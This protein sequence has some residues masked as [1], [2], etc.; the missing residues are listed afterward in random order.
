MNKFDKPY[1]IITKF[2]QKKILEL[3][4][5][6]SK[7]E[8]HELI[9]Y[10]YINQLPLNIFN[11]SGNNLIHEIINI[12]NTTELS[13][14]NGIK[15]LVLNNVNPDKINKDNITP[16][17]LA[18]S[19]QFEDI[20]K[21]LVEIKVNINAQD[22]MKSTPVHYLLKGDIKMFEIKEIKSLV[23]Y[24]KSPNINKNKLI[25]KL[26][27]DI[28]NNL[29]TNLDVPLLDT[30]KKTIFNIISEDSSIK[31]YS[32]HL[33][34]EIAKKSL[35]ELSTLDSTNNLLL[36]YKEFIKSKITSL[37][38]INKI[39]I[40]IH[41]KE[42]TS[43]GPED[44][45]EPDLS[46][47]G[48]IKNG[49]NKKYI[50]KLFKD[51]I[52]DIKNLNSRFKVTQH[53]TQLETTGEYFIKIFAYYL[54]KHEKDTRYIVDIDNHLYYD[55]GP[56]PGNLIIPKFTK[57]NK[58]MIH[59]YAIDNESP[60]IDI[61]NMRYTAAGRPLII[62]RFNDAPIA[63]IAPI[64]IPLPINN[65]FD[66]IYNLIYYLTNDIDFVI[67]DV[68]IQGII[69]INDL[70]VS[71]ILIYIWYLAILKPDKLNGFINIL[72]THLN[73]IGVAGDPNIIL[74]TAAAVP[75]LPGRINPFIIMHPLRINSFAPNIV[76]LYVAG[77]SLI[78]PPPPLP[79]PPI[80]YINPEGLPIGN[81]YYNI[82]FHTFI[83]KWM[84]AYNDNKYTH[85]GLWLFNMYNEY[86]MIWG[87]Y[88]NPAL[89][90][91]QIPYLLLLLV[92]S[93]INNSSNILQGIYSIS[94]QFYHNIINDHV[95]L[96]NYIIYL[97]DINI[98]IPIIDVNTFYNNSNINIACEKI[99]NI[100]SEMTNKPLLQTILNIIFLLKNYHL[101]PPPVGGAVHPFY[102]R[103][104]Q[105]LHLY[106]YTNFKNFI[107]DPHNKYSPIYNMST[108]MKIYRNNFHTGYEYQHFLIAYI[109]GM[110]YQGCVPA[111]KNVRLHR[112]ANLIANQRFDNIVSE[113]NR[114]GKGNKKDTSKPQSL[115]NELTIPIISTNGS[116]LG[117]AVIPANLAKNIPGNIL[118]VG[119]GPNTN[120]PQ[121]LL[122]NALSQHAVE[123]LSNANTLGDKQKI[124]LYNRLHRIKLPLSHIS[125][126]T[127]LYY[128]IPTYYN[129]FYMLIKNIGTF[130]SKIN[131][132]IIK[133]ERII[134]QTVRGT[135]T[136]L[137][138]VFTE[139]YPELVF[140]CKQLEYNIN[141]IKQFNEL[142]KDDDDINKFN[143]DKDNTLG[144][145]VFKK[146][147][148]LENYDFSELAKI[149]NKINSYY[150]IY[151]YIYRQ[152]RMID[153]PAFNYYQIPINDNSNKYDYYNN[154]NNTLPNNIT[155][156][157]QLN[158]DTFPTNPVVGVPGP[159]NLKN[160]NNLNIGNYENLLLEY[161]QGKYPTNN[162]LLFNNNFISAKNETV[163][164]SLYNSLKL[165]FELVIKKIISDYCIPANQININEIDNILDALNIPLGENKSLIKY[166][167]LC[168]V[169]QTGIIDIINNYIESSI[170][171]YYETMI[172][173]NGLGNIDIYINNNIKNLLNIENLE[174][175]LTLEDYANISINKHELVN[176]LKLKE[177]LLLYSDDLTNLSRFK[178]TYEVKI[179]E[180]ILMILL[181]NNINLNLSDIENNTPID[182][183]IKQ[184]NYNILKKL[185]NQDIFVMNN[186]YNNY[187]YNNSLM[188]IKKIITTNDISKEKLCN[189]LN[190]FGAHLYK[191]INSLI[192]ANE[193]FG[194]NILKN[195]EESFWI[196]SY[197]TLK[198]LTKLLYNIDEDFTMKDLNYIV[199]SLYFNINDLNK[200]YLD[201]NIK[202]FNI[203]ENPNSI[204]KSHI[205]N[206]I[207]QEIENLEKQ[208]QNKE[209][210]LKTVTN[211]NIRN[212][213]NND[214][215]KITNDLNKYNLNK[216]DIENYINIHTN[217]IINHNLKDEQQLQFINGWN[218]LLNND[219]TMKPNNYNLLLLY[220]LEKQKN[221]ITDKK[222]NELK[223]ILPVFKHISHLVET[224]FTTKKYIVDN[225]IL[226][227][228][229]E[230]II[231]ITRLVIGTNLELIIRKVLYS[232][233]N[234][235]LL[236]NI[237]I[238]L[239]ID[240]V[241][242]NKLNGYNFSLKTKLYKD[243]CK[244]M[245][246]YAL[247]VFENNIDENEF[248]PLTMRDLLLSYFDLFNFTQL[249]I[250]DNIITILKTQ[251][252]DYFDTFGYRCI[253]LWLVNTEN[254]FKYFIKNYRLLEMQIILN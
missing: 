150:Y 68:D 14:L 239:S 80:A 254:I 16:L 64:V 74:P 9:Q 136:N 63:P 48:L 88:L 109:F 123:L 137:K 102:D 95:D 206:D 49:D 66:V 141:S 37:L 99:L 50:K 91:D 24:N 39:P 46:N 115:I 101:D 217:K 47:Y 180:K 209:E 6:A 60:I 55:K 181:A 71:N 32:N 202:S 82:S 228:I 185:K 23:P 44:P 35:T 240:I 200:D 40:E 38:G 42:L 178:N 241:F 231:E 152:N 247:E 226:K 210:L 227:D 173:N 238:E 190:N 191:D 140:N 162:Y 29:L 61:K 164:P 121:S 130:Q 26:K 250:P 163:P 86:A 146:F 2:D 221:I 134:D 10:A 51:T 8:I 135:T 216:D 223:N 43:W 13:K 143:D 45:G 158:F 58:D 118:I 179:N 53:Y 176:K 15:L 76:G 205:L 125:D 147:Q 170:Y 18:C 120:P 244:E 28:I 201:E 213:I 96:N 195:L 131:I 248:I 184:N 111:I 233:F 73:T 171:Y 193:S 246:K 214:I 218:Q 199:S 245:V 81:I 117:R 186:K 177:T 87:R 36:Y 166:E 105:F 70:L 20:V 89:Y 169:L 30:L 252:I 204:F 25:N 243:L 157:I 65:K 151:Y 229:Y 98:P 7:L 69:N 127:D 175:N 219:L 237:N 52:G 34:N 128:F 84:D 4:K 167:I 242:N 77:P 187:I 94:K 3:F 72:Q 222:F 21:Y 57:L 182:H 56:G 107:D 156:N 144:I 139:L 155:H 159:T 251:I 183:L 148:K 129:Y 85:V 132:L 230:I 249:K 11:D 192:F 188:L 113:Y 207:K 5:Y 93:L 112:N 138:Q 203:Y 79:P 165:F 160:Y 116:Q 236:D 12:K 108:N 153:L 124:E 133:I 225:I 211:N 149:L 67:T 41:P 196:S 104:N 122:Y 142:Y 197:L 174:I 22:N 78:F 19:N 232:Y 126:D 253:M 33:K 220:L 97:L 212:I 54:K 198:Y 100:Y 194:N 106:N 189:L 62:S 234:E 172:L 161:Y 27:H 90:D 119:N 17:H 114:L 235:S 92:S 110:H 168:N 224:Y 1:N 103:I 154:D 208:K 215:A 59:K 145:D 31:D 83:K 75:G